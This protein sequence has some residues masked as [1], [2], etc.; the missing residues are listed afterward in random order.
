MLSPSD[1]RSLQLRTRFAGVCSPSLGASHQVP[2]RRWP[3]YWASL[4]K[5]MPESGRSKAARVAGLAKGKF[6]GN[7][8]GQGQI[9]GHILSLNLSLNLGRN[10]CEGYNFSDSRAIQGQIKDKLCP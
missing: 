2:S 1:S 3:S 6:K 8:E 9:Q 5:G 4:P 7:P 10:P